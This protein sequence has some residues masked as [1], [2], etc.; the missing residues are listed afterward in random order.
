MDKQISVVI[1]SYNS[2]KT[3]SYTLDSLLKQKGDYIK[4]IIVAD[5]SD[6]P[7]MKDIIAK[8][9]PGVKFINTGTRVMPALGRN[10]GAGQATGKILAF[11]D[12]DA[13]AVEDWSEKIALAYGKGYKAGGGGVELPGFQRNNSIAAAQY[14]LQLNEFI[15]AGRERV[16]SILPGVNIFCER[17]LF[18]RVGGFPEVRASEDTLFGLAVSRHTRYWFVPGITVAHIFREDLKGFLNNQELLGKYIILYRR[19]YYSSPIYRGIIPVLLFPAIIT[20]KTLRMIVRIA[21]SRRG[22]ILRFFKVSPLFMKGMVYWSRGFLK[23]CFE[24]T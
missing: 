20:F 11:L 16:K 23:G 17:E 19:K 4:E 7:G 24:K 10:L 14:Y 1:P 18:N 21:L 13:I 12:S 3:I 6:N 2:Q 8:Y 22:E 5:S 15:P 9:S